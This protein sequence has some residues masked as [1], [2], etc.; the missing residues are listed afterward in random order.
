MAASKIRSLNILHHVSSG[1]SF[2]LILIEELGSKTHSNY[3]LKVREHLYDLLVKDGHEPSKNLLDIHQRPTCKDVFISIS[4]CPQ[5]TLLAWGPRTLGCDIELSSRINKKMI[6]RISTPQELEE[7]PELSHLW[8]A[9]EAAFKAIS[10]SI[11]LLSSVEIIEWQKEIATHWQ[12]YKAKNASVNKVV[13]MGQSCL[14]M[15]HSIS[16]FVTY[17]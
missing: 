11:K 9:K 14:I 17:P 2:N 5:H 1:E 13:G 16:F 12:T 6:G 15:N 3:R 8:T 7:A 10:S 4:H